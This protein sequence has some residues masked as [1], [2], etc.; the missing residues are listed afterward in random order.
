MAFTS[1]NL[2]LPSGGVVL[3]SILIIC[4]TY[5]LFRFPKQDL[6][7]PPGPKGLPVLGN[8]N[9]LPKHGA[10]EWHHWLTHKDLYGPISS[11]TVLGQTFVILNDADITLELLRDRAVVNSGRPILIYGGEMIGWKN[12]L[13]MLQPNEL[14][15]AYRKNMAKVASSAATLSVF[16]RVQEEEAVHF[17][18]NLLDSPD[19]LF[20]HIRKEAGAVILR[21]IYGYT[22]EAHGSDPLVD[23]AEKAMADFA[24]VT[25]PGRY[26]V[27][28]FPFCKLVRRHVHIRS[29]DSLS[30]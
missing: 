12:G 13:A 21:I 1:M 19:N 30:Q 18:A 5:F 15:K 24:D 28:I 17:L 22:P 10:L 8:I 3:L 27:D 9:D 7:F 11:I 16:D 6:P 2:S 26:M 14:F 20:A 4:L 23:L 25:S 29:A